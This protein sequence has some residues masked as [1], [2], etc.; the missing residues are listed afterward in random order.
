M[1]Q[2]PPVLFATP[3]DPG[4]GVGAPLPPGRLGFEQV[5]AALV[6]DGLVATSDLERIRFSAQGARNASEVHPLV[7]LANL[8]LA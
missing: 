4:A 6:A 1:E 3:A 7:L 2:R 8:K 5:V